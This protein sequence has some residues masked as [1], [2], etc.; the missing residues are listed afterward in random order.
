MK[1]I[2]QRTK[3]LMYLRFFQNNLYSDYGKNL[4]ECRESGEI[5]EIISRAAQDPTKKIYNFYGDQVLEMNNLDELNKHNILNQMIDL[6]T[7]RQMK[8]RIVLNEKEIKYFLDIID[9]KFFESIK[10]D[11]MNEVYYNCL[12]NH[13]TKNINTI[14]PQ[15]KESP[16][17]Q[18]INVKQQ[19]VHKKDNKLAIIEF[20]DSDVSEENNNSQKMK[21]KRRTNLL[22]N[23][24]NERQEILNKSQEG[25]LQGLS[26]I[27]EEI[28]KKSLNDIYQDLA[29]AKQPNKTPQI[30][31]PKENNKTNNPLNKEI[32]IH[33]NTSNFHNQNQNA[34]KT[35]NKNPI[36]E[37]IKNTQVHDNRQ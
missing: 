36:L 16:N 31:P 3:F 9:T 10:D 13:N 19:K 5:K 24:S 26:Q 1:E 8:D 6:M 2:I 15:F 33:Q 35:N 18:T 23:V 7:K 4:D 30:N 11:I 27:S 25:G 34:E 17:L 21:R 32:D 14:I 20:T 29:N 37:Q 22:E 12:R 28:K